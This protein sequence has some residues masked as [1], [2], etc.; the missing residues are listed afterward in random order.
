MENEIDWLAVR[1]SDAVGDPTV[2]ISNPEVFRNLTKVAI[3]AYREGV[4]VSG[5]QM[6]EI[7]E[8]V[9]TER[10]NGDPAGIGLAV[11]YSSHIMRI[12]EALVL[13]DETSETVSPN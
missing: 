6:M 5:N 7:V 3:Q 11:F 4:W 13:Y 12:W 9:L 8:N 1:I 2:N 10:M